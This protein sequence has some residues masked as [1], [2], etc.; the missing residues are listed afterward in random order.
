[1]TTFKR[2]LIIAGPNGAGKTVFAT[3][4]LPNEAKCPT[5]INADLITLGLSSPT[6]TWWMSGWCTTIRGTSPCDRKWKVRHGHTKARKPRTSSEIA[7]PGLRWR[8]RSPAPGCG[9]LASPSHGYDRGCGCIQG[10]K[11]R[12]GEGRRNIH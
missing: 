2:I 6:G 4:F 11:S 5:F 10:R 3:E 8:R 12:L 7:R 9:T 1:M